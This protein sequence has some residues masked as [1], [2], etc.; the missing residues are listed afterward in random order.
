MS[1]IDSSERALN[2]INQL[3]LAGRVPQNTVLKGSCYLLPY[4]DAYFDYVYSRCVLFLHPYIAD[5]RLGLT[6]VLEEM[7][8]VLKPGG[9]VALNILR[10]EGRKLVEFEQYLMPE[11]LITAAEKLGLEHQQLL[12]PENSATKS[13]QEST[14]TQ[15]ATYYYDFQYFIFKKK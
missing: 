10:G 12:I 2:H 14:H 8:R 15:N 1:A 5:T 11:Q 9:I 7:T 13:K 6:K 4:P 3:E